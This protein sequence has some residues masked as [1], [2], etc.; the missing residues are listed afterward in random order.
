MGKKAEAI[1]SQLDDLE[2]LAEDKQ[3][4]VKEFAT[5]QSLNQVA[6]IINERL[7]SLWFQKSRVNWQLQGDNNMRF[8]HCLAPNFRNDYISELKVGEIVYSDPMLVKSLA[9]NYFAGLFKKMD[10]VPFSLERIP[11]QSLSQEQVNF[12]ARPFSEIEIYDGLM[13][14]GSSKSPRLD[15][16]NF[17][18]YKKAWSFMK[19]DILSIFSAFH[20]TGKSPKGINSSFLVLVP[21]VA[22]ACSLPEFCPISLIN[23]IY[24]II[25][26]V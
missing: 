11:F 13:S 18:F 5:V 9:R 7:D 8:F 22:G 15:G 25:S 17:L 3:L 2:V 1:N 23:G 14:C 12:L 4:I 26:K 16:L 10:L 24:K 6:S 19:M 20:C 21:K